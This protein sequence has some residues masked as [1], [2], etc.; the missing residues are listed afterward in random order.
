[1]SPDESNT[2]SSEKSKRRMKVTAEFERELHPEDVKSFVINCFEPE[3]DV[4][5][6]DAE[7]GETEYTGE[8]GGNI[9]D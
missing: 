9:D 2:I 7:T 6:I 4:T 1:M 8:W 5:V 3:D